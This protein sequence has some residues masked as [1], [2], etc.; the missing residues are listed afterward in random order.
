MVTE[1]DA[2]YTGLLDGMQHTD[3]MMKVAEAFMDG[4]VDGTRP[5]RPHILAKVAEYME[6]QEEDQ[7]D[8]TSES[9][10]DFVRSVIA[11]A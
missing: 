10:A 5:D 8:E 4:L 11:T 7:S 3:D 6:A 9:L 2:F 1:S